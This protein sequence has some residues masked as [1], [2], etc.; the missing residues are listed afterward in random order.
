MANSNRS[1]AWRACHW[2]AMDRDAWQAAHEPGDEFTDAGAAASWAPRSDENVELA[3]GRYLA[4]LTRS[5]RLRDVPRVGDRVDLEV[6]R[7]FAHELGVT[8][9]PITVLNILVC[10]AQAVRVMDATADLTRFKRVLRRLEHRAKPSREVNGRLIPPNE[11]VHIAQAM[12]A[13]AKAARCQRKMAAVLYRDAAL[14]LAATLCPLRR[15]NWQSVR[16]GHH[17]N[18]TVTGARLSFEDHEMKGRRALQLQLPP[19]VA[20]ALRCYV[21]IYRPRLLRA[22]QPD[23]G[24]LW[25]SRSGNDMS[26]DVMGKKVKVCLRRRTGKAFSFH[27]FRHSAATFISEVAPEAALLATGALLHR[28]YRTTLH[29]YVRGKQRSA[30]RKYQSLVKDVMRTG[31]RRRRRA[32]RHR[33]TRSP[34]RPR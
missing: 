2:P 18:F 30:M 26:G 17:L 6:L 7:R 23:S 9:A 4:F 5:G 14:I 19:E 31:R 8:L 21:I 1:A 33:R 12:M 22:G 29:H 28:K 16:I 24:C 3:Y 11:L 25:V 27:M 32:R 15:G 34:R 10:L 20:E 13:E